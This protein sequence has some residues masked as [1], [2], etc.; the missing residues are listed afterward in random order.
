MLS[1]FYPSFIWKKFEFFW[2]GFFTNII[3]NGRKNKAMIIYS[4][5][6]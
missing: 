4:A 3:I 2:K 5:I 1:I 6:L